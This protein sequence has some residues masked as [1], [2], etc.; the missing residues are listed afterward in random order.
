MPVGEAIELQKAEVVKVKK[1]NYTACKTIITD[2][3]Y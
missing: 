3:I 1:L 2:Y